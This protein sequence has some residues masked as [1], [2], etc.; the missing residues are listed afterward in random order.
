MNSSNSWYPF[1]IPWSN[2]KGKPVKVII[3]DVYLLAAPKADQEVC[4]HP[5]HSLVVFLAP[6]TR[7]CF[8]DR[9]PCPLC[10]QYDEEE[11]ERRQ[12][13]VKQEKLQNAELLQER[14]TEGMSDEEQQKN[15]SF[16]NSLITKAT[17][18][19]SSQG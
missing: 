2:L 5:F 16:T 8:S 10:E 9:E 7:I 6:R 19:I 1:R 11:E 12:Q 17:I 3:E 4:S 18:N 15:S 14:S 13:A